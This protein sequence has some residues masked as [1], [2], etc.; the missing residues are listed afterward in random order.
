MKKLGK[1]L[2]SMS[3]VVALCLMLLPAAFAA[4][5]GEE[6]PLPESILYYGTIEQIIQT[7]DG[8]V[9]AL[10]LS[11]ERQG[12]YVMNLSDETVWIDSGKKTASNPAT[13]EVGEAVYICHSAISTQSLPPQSSA[14][15]VVR[16]IPQDAGCAQ[17]MTVMPLK[18]KMVW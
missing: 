8:T 9:S 14:Y 11:S 10:C 4:D 12:E 5:T 7:D 3:M 18:I 6:K 1:K 17:Y 15:A 13:L 16:D 2:L